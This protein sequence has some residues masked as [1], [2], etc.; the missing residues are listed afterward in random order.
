MRIRD[1]IVDIQDWFRYHLGLP[2]SGDAAHQRMLA[3]LQDV[4]SQAEE[5]CRH[6]ANGLQHDAIFSAAS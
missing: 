4:G 2:L 5:F 6:F 1:L 3:S